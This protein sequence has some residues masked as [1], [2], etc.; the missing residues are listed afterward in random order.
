MKNKVNKPKSDARIWYMTQMRAS[1]TGQQA[2]MLPILLVL[3]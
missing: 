2:R 3:I 1:E